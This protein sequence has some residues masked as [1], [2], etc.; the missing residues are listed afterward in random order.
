MKKRFKK[1]V[2][3]PVSADRIKELDFD[4]LDNSGR[5]TYD[6]MLIDDFSKLVIPQ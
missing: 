6:D 5:T 2:D 1:I 4:K 3:G